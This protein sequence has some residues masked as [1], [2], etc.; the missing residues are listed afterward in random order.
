MTSIETGDLNEE[1]NC[2]NFG[3]IETAE[4][5]DEQEIIED[6]EGTPAVK[7]AV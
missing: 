5:T 4:T 6:I 3:R 7:Y 1:Y 2:G